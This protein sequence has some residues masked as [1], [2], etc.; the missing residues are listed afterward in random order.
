MYTVHVH[1]YACMH[2]DGIPFNLKSAQKTQNKSVNSPLFEDLADAPGAQ[3]GKTL[4]YHR[5]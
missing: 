1:I 5:G 2:A 3:G 4:S